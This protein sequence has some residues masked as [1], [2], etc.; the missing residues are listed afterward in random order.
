[1]ILTHWSLFSFPFCSQLISFHILHCSSSW[2]YLFVLLCFLPLSPILLSICNS[3][4]LNF[5]LNLSSETSLSASDATS[6]TTSGTRV[7]VASRW[8]LS[9]R[10]CVWPW[11][12]QLWWSCCSSWSSCASPRSST[13]SRQRI[14]SCVSAGEETT[15]VWKK[16][17]FFYPYLV[18]ASK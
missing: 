9:S 12:P 3:T 15:K 10:W 11:A 7:P 1:M 4:W 18:C 17:G 16:V 2:S 8:L 13:C 14:R 5:S 6:R